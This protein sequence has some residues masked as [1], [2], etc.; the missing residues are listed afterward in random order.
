MLENAMSV[1][2]KAFAITTTP[3]SL[4]SMSSQGISFTLSNNS[5]KVVALKFAS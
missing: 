2:F 4:V 1:L 5:S 3:R